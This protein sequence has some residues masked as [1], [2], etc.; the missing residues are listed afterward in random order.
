VKVPA[1]FGSKEVTWTIAIRGAT[2]A[3]PGYLRAN[4]QIDALE[5]EAGSGNTPP[6]LAFDADGPR[7][8]ARSASRAAR[9][10]HRPAFRSRSAFARVTTA[11]R[12]EASAAPGRGAVPV[13]LTWSA[14]QCPATLRVRAP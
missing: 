10:R 6:A 7:A 2:Y 8:A 4:W 14:H 12:R 11:R 1:D 13:T 5:G 9:F 3:I